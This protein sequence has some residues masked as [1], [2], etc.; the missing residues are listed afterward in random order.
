MVTLG[1]TSESYGYLW[2][3][4]KDGYGC[5]GFGGQEINVLPYANMVTVIQATPTSSNKAYG[6]IHEEILKTSIIGIEE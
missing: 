6:D 3:I 5:R 2:W 4:F 1:I